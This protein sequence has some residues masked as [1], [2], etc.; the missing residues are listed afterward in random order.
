MEKKD[1][2]IHRDV[3]DF[4]PK[5]VGQFTSRQVLCIIA[6]T[7]IFYAWKFFLVS[8]LGLTTISYLPACIPA[9]IPAAFG[10]GHLVLGMP[11]ER[12][13]KF[14][15]INNIFAK[16]H[17]VFRTHNYISIEYDKALKEIESNKTEK[18]KK[19]DKINISDP[20]CKSVD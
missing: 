5:L 17:R 18:R 13:L 7:A 9:S 12:Y 2:D 20:E 14:I 11:V 3:R 8:I 16:R 10:W 19:N 1:V 15:L 6:I 4:E